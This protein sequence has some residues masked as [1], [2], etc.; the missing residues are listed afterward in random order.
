MSN[1]ANFRVDIERV[2]GKSRAHATVTLMVANKAAVSRNTSPKAAETLS[3][4]FIPEVNLIAARMRLQTPWAE[5][6]HMRVVIRVS[7]IMAGPA[8]PPAFKPGD[9]LREDTRVEDED[10]GHDD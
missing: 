10:G 8:S 2:P 6:N 1:S 4:R 9:G 5:R 3:R 7:G